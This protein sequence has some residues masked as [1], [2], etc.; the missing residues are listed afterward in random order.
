MKTF[1]VSDLH[2]QKKVYDSIIKYFSAIDD[3][4]TLYILG[5][6]VDKGYDGIGILQDI[7]NRKNITIKMI[8]GNHELMLYDYLKDTNIKDF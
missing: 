1:I 6:V 5:D 7:I 8:A 4:T 2:G 3:E